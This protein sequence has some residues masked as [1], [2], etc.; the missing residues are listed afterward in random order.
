MVN[1][2]T[3]FQYYN[4]NGKVVDLNLQ[5]GKTWNEQK[6]S[7]KMIN[8]IFNLVDDGDG[9]VQEEEFLLLKTILKYADTLCGTK[10]GDNRLVS[11]ELINIINKIK[12]KELSIDKFKTESILQI[13]PKEYSLESLK[14]RYPEINYQYENDCGSILIKDKRT[15]KKVLRLSNDRDGFYITDFNNNDQENCFRNYNNKGILNFYDPDYKSEQRRYPIVEY[16]NKDICTKSKFG[17]PTTGK[18]IEKH[19]KMIDSKNVLTLLSK[20]KELYG[21]SMIDAIKGEWGLDKDL[22]QKLLN[23]IENCLEMYY[24]YEKNYVNNNS[25]VS[26]KWHTGD[27]YSI[28]NKND[29]LT[30]KNNKTRKTRT[31]DLNKL[32]EKLDFV[33][34]VAVKAALIKMPGEILMDIAI[35]G[36]ELKGANWLDKLTSPQGAAACY[37]NHTNNIT[38]GINGDFIE[39]LIHEIG[40]S[41]DFKRSSYNFNKSTVES[42]QTFRNTF[43]RELENFRKDNNAHDWNNRDIFGNT[44]IRKEGGRHISNYATENEKECFA[45]IYALLTTG[46]CASADLLEDYFTDTIKVAKQ[47]LNEIRKLPYDIRNC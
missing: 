38:L 21:E 22:K 3:N 45:E 31:I 41:V 2:N 27:N 40:H 43:N 47:I 28:I 6:T 4:Q 23:H 33:Q 9:I 1:S 7:H 42:D 46:S 37:N 17:I 14:K 18:N 11:N 29:I 30:I 5:V 12:N 44:Y 26:N 15:N 34:K 13:D 20:Y 19:I 24:G 16:I 39:P 35:E 32:V 8:T 36:I 25:Q 10:D